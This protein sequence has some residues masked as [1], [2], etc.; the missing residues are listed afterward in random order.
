MNLSS[1]IGKFFQSQHKLNDLP[2]SIFMFYISLARNFFYES[3]T[4]VV[5]G[6]LN[7]V[8]DILTFVLIIKT[9][10]TLI[11]PGTFE[12]QIEKLEDMLGFNLFVP[13]MSISASLIIIVILVVL[14]N[15]V[16]G[17]IGLKIL[18][19]VR[20]KLQINGPKL[21]IF[22]DEYQNRQFSIHHLPD[23]YESITKI[24]QICFFFLGLIP[25]I[26][27]LN[28]LVGVMI[29]LSVPIFT[30]IVIIHQRKIF[31]LRLDAQKSKENIGEMDES[32]YSETARKDTR[33]I[34]YNR[35]NTLIANILSGL[36]LIVIIIAFFS[37][38]QSNQI[39]TITALFLIFSMRFSLIYAREFS[40]TMSKLIN[41]RQH[42]VY[43]AIDEANVSRL[44]E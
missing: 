27:Y 13:D 39:D 8:F 36:T 32:E 30:L 28:V 12:S 16:V 40:D 2:L 29:A 38:G 26:F 20:T 9:F 35:S 41:Q 14:S 33:H 17:V 22:D 21:N 3:A 18:M 4:I 25:F 1:L 42:L 44:N 19:R 23:G 7:R 37:Q 34:Y 6:M 43:S 24:I 11:D 31:Q 5:S 10:V 15:Y